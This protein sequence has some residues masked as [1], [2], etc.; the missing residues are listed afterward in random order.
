MASS[1]GVVFALRMA[2]VFR[3]LNLPRARP[4]LYVVQE[5]DRLRR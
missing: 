2:A 1:A 5:H 3:G 4:R